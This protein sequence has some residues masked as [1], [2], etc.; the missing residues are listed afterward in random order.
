MPERA[1][2][3]AFDG[4]AA[5]ADGA[6]PMRCRFSVV[7]DPR[8]K[9][10]IIPVEDVRED[11]LAAHGVRKTFDRLGARLQRSAGIDPELEPLI[12]QPKQG[13]GARPHL[14]AL[15]VVL[16]PVRLVEILA[17]TCFAARL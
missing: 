2:A 16:P 8:G 3:A 14:Q 5:G 1:E 15:Q 4:S 17:A 9:L 13:L 11:L 10:A 7:S 12:S 6:S